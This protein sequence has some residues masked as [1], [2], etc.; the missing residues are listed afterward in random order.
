MNFIVFPLDRT[1]N[2]RL[3]L[4]I[5]MGSNV[6]P[7]F[8]SNSQYLPFFFSHFPEEVCSLQEE[9]SG[10]LRCNLISDDVMLQYESL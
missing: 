7:S 9:L 10:M 4:S 3:S 1:E 5:D 6:E 2:T 8:P